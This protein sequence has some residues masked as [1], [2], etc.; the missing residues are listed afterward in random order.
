ME[1]GGKMSAPSASWENT[2][3]LE[4]KGI[5][6]KKRCTITNPCTY[7]AKS[8]NRTREVE[9]ECSH[10]CATPAPQK[11]HSCFNLKF[12]SIIQ[13]SPSKDYTHSNGLAL[14]SVNQLLLPLSFKA[15]EYS[16]HVVRTED[17]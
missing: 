9:G 3:A 10:H 4:G 17:L 11:K 12:R 15:T 13:N 16:L 6:F 2:L 5:T 1:R 8:R 14:L 7:S